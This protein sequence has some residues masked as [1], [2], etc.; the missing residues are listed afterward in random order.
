MSDADDLKAR[1]ATLRQHLRETLGVKGRDLDHALRRARRQL[2]RGL[3]Q[4][5]TRIVEA[6]AMLGHPKLERLVDYEARR[7][8]YAAFDAHLGSIDLAD[9]RW[10]RFL[11]LAAIVAFNL[12]VVTALFITWLV[13][14]GYL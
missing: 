13:W 5:G 11:E 9:Q 12:I 10:G 2:P 1:G 7:A 14:S 3:R 4:A 8:D 6:D